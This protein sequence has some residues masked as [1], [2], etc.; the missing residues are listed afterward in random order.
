[1]YR[2]LFQTNIIVS[3]ILLILI[4]CTAIKPVR[5]VLINTTI[6]V[7]EPDK[8]R[9]TIPFSIDLHSFINTLDS[10]MFRS[11]GT[12]DSWNCDGNNCIAY[13][14]DRGDLGVSLQNNNLSVKTQLTYQARFGRKFMGSIRTLASS[15]KQ[16][17]NIGLNSALNW[18]NDWQLVTN[19]TSVPITGEDYK[20]TDFNYDVTPRIILTLQHRFDEKLSAL[21]RKA[22]QYFNIKT[23]L[24][25]AWDKIQVPIKVH[26]QIWFVVNPDSVSVSRIHGDNQNLQVSIGISCY[27]K[28]YYTETQPVIKKMPIPG[29]SV[30]NDSLAAFHINLYGELS[31]IEATKLANDQLKNK[32]FAIGSRHLIID[33]IQINGTGNKLII[34]VRISG[35][36]KGVVYFVATPYYDPE[37]NMIL[38]KDFDFSI[39]TKNVLIKL[40][41]WMLHDEF[42]NLVSS[43]LKYNVTNQLKKAQDD[44]TIAIN[45]KIGTDLQLTGAITSLSTLGVFITDKGLKTVVTANGSIKAFI[46]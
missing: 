27:P 20:F 39:E 46:E 17:L 37:S 8:S 1:M 14:I 33:D 31:Y 40:A 5:P 22:S 18:N 19:T 10:T 43:K 38:V 16:T 26:D 15:G 25:R 21:D 41:N 30:R 11:F 42:K 3:G 4:S 24:E 9:I 45:R 29:F 44:L 23:I 7:P 35:T 13:K 2:K 36:V 6:T 34:Q 32:D 28:V 12:L